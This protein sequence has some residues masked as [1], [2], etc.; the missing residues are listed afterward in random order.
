MASTKRARIVTIAFWLLM[1]AAA[2]RAQEIPGFAKNGLYVGGTAVP[3]FTLDGITFDGQTYYQEIGGEEILILPR[4]DPKSTLRAVVGFRTTRGAFEVGYER[5][6][7]AGT[8]LDFK[9]EAEFHALNF[10][11]RIY[12]LTSG[13][14]QPYGLLGLSLP[15]LTIKDGSFLEGGVADGSFR[16]FGINTE[17]GATVFPHPRVGI[18]AGYR[19]RVMWFDSAKG[20]SH[21]TYELRPRF[22]ETTG[23]LSL[24]AT[25]TF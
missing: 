3:D 18:S 17:A 15:W 24:S 19:Y 10:D 12:V 1:F 2:A 11:E 25:F 16:G 13:R 22:R 4:L 14:V 5:T 7:H 21:T 20:I 23:G 9:D 6:R 8:F